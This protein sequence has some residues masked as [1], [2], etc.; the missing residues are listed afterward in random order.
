MLQLGK[1]LLFYLI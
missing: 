1:Q